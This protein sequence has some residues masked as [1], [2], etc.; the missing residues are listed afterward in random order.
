MSLKVLIERRVPK[1]K[2]TEALTL[3]TQIRAAASIQ[4]GY[5]SGET[6]RNQDNPEEYIVISSWH[7]LEDWNNWKATEERASIQ[8]R[9]DSLLGSPTQYRVF[10]YPEKQR[11][12]WA[13]FWDNVMDK[14]VGSGD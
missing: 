3:L 4:P 5:I 2:Q 13:N 11:V 14:T 8:G 10:T 12:D 6:L 1:D 7:S 9:I